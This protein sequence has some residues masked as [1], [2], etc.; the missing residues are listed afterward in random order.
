MSKNLK[1]LHK[2]IRKNLMM[3]FVWFLMSNR[4]LFICEGV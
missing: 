3:M 1:N 2:E 4:V